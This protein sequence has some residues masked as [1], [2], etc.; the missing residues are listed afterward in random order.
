MGIFGTVS[1]QETLNIQSRCLTLSMKGERRSMGGS[2][3]RSWGRGP[4]RALLIRPL[5]QSWPAMPMPRLSSSSFFSSSTLMAWSRFMLLVFRAS[6]A[7]SL[8]QGG[9]W[10]WTHTHTHTHT[11]T[12][13]LFPC[14]LSYATVSK[15]YNEGKYAFC[16]LKREEAV[17]IRF[18]NNQQKIGFL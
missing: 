17:V 8:W 10:T 3:E 2:L 18:K 11:H 12:F 9:T 1:H 13:Y 7:G 4:P 16:S 15:N 14:L 6:S 5:L